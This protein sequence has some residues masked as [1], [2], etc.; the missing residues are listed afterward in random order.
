MTI[1]TPPMGWNTWNTF[2][3]DINEDLILRSADVLVETGLAAAEYKYVVVDDCWSLRERDK[4]GHLVA[5]P[6]KFPHGMKYLADELHRRGLKFG[7]YSCSGALTCAEYPGSLNREY[8]DARTFARWGV[9]LLKY[10]YCFRPQSPD[11]ETLFRR[12]GL[13]LANSG[14]DILF[15]GC[16]WGADD[17][18]KWIGTTGAGMWRSTP[19]IFD[20]FDSIKDLIKRQYGILPYGGVGCFNDMDMLVVGMHGKGNVGLKG[21]TDD[22]YRLHFA[23]W[24]LLASPLMIGCDVRNMDETTYAILT[25]K[26]L[27]AISQDTRG[28][29]PYIRRFFDCDDLPIVVRILG[30]G[31]VALGLFNMTE[32][33]ANFWVPAD[34]LGVPVFS[35]KKL[36]GEEVYTGKTIESRNGVLLDKVPPHA[37]AVYRL[38]VVNAK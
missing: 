14:R 32:G 17:T 22:E 37:C 21:C 6:E 3:K 18:P 35:G 13:A 20:S 25:N 29:R 11:G 30:N 24:C 10:D 19:D 5:D 4:N 2:A 15:S 23:A 12:M 7:M 26:P 28:N 36:V 34:D 33:N 38:R 16:S 1:H 31:D 27:L 8:L 9:D